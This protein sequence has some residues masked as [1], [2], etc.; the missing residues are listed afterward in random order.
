MSRSFGGVGIHA[1]TQVRQLYG[2]GRHVE[3]GDFSPTLS[4]AECR[5]RLVIFFIVS[6]GLT[7][8]HKTPKP[9]GLNHGKHARCGDALPREQATQIAAV[10]ARLSRLGYRGLDGG[11]QVGASE[12]YGGFAAWRRPQALRESQE[13]N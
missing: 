13:A 6:S 8:G 9:A 4:S 10:V 11:D 2:V 7:P 5:F 1:A 12:L 3:F